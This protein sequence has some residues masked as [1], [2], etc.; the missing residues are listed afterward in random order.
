MYVTLRDGDP[1]ELPQ[2]YLYSNPQNDPDAQQLNLPSPGA[3]YGSYA[4]WLIGFLA[5]FYLMANQ[6]VKK[7]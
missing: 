7:H 2:V 6:V 5:L 1:S 4:V 3:I